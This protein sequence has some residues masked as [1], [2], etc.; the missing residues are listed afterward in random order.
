MSAEQELFSLEHEVKPSQAREQLD[1]YAEL[2]CLFHGSDNPNITELTPREPH[3]DND[4][5][6][7]KVVCAGESPEMAIFSAIYRR[8]DP[9]RNRGRTIV[10][11]EGGI[12]DKDARL[13]GKADAWKVEQIQAEDLEG[14]VYVLS[15][16]DFALYD[17]REREHRS[18]KA[19]T[20]I[21]RL[22]VK[23]SDLRGEVSSL[24][25]RKRQV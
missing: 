2:G 14:Y 17:E 18:T 19:I 23:A 10:D 3:G 25:L 6:G 20:P 1:R 4:I 11:Y 21:A 22:V 9:K 8:K 16:K 7:E 24:L 12:G 13:I 15:P 5:P